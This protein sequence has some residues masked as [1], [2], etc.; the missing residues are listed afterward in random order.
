[1]RPKNFAYVLIMIVFLLGVA[2]VIVVGMGLQPNVSSVSASNDDTNSPLEPKGAID[3]FRG[4]FKSPLA[5]FL[6]QIIVIFPTAKI[7][8]KILKKIGQPEVCGEIVAG[9]FL[10][11]S[12]LGT[13][14]PNIY[15]FVFPQHSLGTLRLMSQLGILIFMF[16]VGMEFK[17]TSFKKRI[18]SALF[19]SH[20]G[21]IVPFFLGTWLSL[22]LYRSYAPAGVRFDDFALFM[23]IAMSITA[24]PVLAR[25]IQEKGLT[26]TPLGTMAVAAA[27][28]DDV[29]AWTAFAFIVAGVGTSSISIM[30]YTVLLFIIFVMTM[31]FIARPI[32]EGVVGIK[33]ERPS[34][35]HIV[36]VLLIL[37]IS[38]L[39]TELIGIHALFGAFL[40]GLVMPRNPKFRQFIEQRFEYFSGAFLLPLFFAVT[41]LRT[42]IGLLSD[43][44]SWLV[45]LLVFLVAIAGK[46]LASAATARF[47]GMD[48]KG[49][50]SLGALMNTRGLMELIVLNIGYEMNIFTKKIF[51]MMILMAVSTTLMTSP[52]LNLFSYLFRSKQKMAKNGQ[53]A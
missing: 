15:D 48:W 29:T 52:L 50:L 22:F 31:M 53:A 33:L 43:M 34:N 14:L 20:S 18:N 7:F 49:S 1:M 16:L 11:P 6:M 9:I 24:F 39:F 42:Q 13:F 23:G 17:I 32:M 10:G 37:F 46:F 35:D 8:G 45:C 3:Y 40:S 12:L 28:I 36:I 26:Q 41:G 19:I 47:V 5:L 44:R 4:H 51:A 38:A 25:I 27:A 2:R 21:I 30:A